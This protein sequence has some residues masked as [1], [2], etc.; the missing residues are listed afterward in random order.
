MRAAV[1]FEVVVVKPLDCARDLAS[2]DRAGNLLFTRCVLRLKLFLRQGDRRVV[3]ETSRGVQDEVVLLE[4]VHAE[5]ETERE[6]AVLK[7]VEGN[8]ET[9]TSNYNVESDSLTRTQG[10]ATSVVQGLGCR[11]GQAQLALV[12]VGDADG[13]DARHGV[14]AEPHGLAVDRAEDEARDSFVPNLCTAL[15]ERTAFTS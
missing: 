4:D 14:D 1:L 13:A 6:A 5:Q 7:H 3:D 15:E 2:A 11:N 10:L 9:P 8:V 12:E